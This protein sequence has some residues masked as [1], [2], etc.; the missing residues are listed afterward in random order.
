MKL[1]Y[2]NHRKLVIIDGCIGYLGGFNVADEYVG[3]SKK[4]GNWRDTH[5]RLT[6]SCV[7]DMNVRFM[8]DWRSA[9]KEPLL[10]ASAYFNKVIGQGSSGV[11]IVSCGPDSRQSEIKRGYLKMITSAR[12]S[13]YLQTPYFVPDASVIESL[14]TPYSPAWTCAS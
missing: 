2:R 8:M 7:H 14:K 6:G 13:I 5:L 4:F 1:N 12:K 9:S 3:R 10:L 11:Q